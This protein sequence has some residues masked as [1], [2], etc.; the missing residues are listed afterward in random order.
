MAASKLNWKLLTLTYC[1]LFLAEMGDKTQL[2]VMS[3]VAQ[4]KAPIPIFLGATLALATVTF[5]GAA[6]GHIISRFIPPAYMQ[7]FAGLL[8][9]VMGI[10]ML[11]N[12]A[13]K[14]F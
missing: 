2:A 9:I 1:L 6:F 13:H 3:L 5:V 10:I 11:W 7:G 4:Y 14:I 8:F 12:A